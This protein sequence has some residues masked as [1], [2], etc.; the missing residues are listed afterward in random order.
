M[1]VI[2]SICKKFGADKKTANMLGDMFQGFLLTFLIGTWTWMLINDSCE[3][4]Q[5]AAPC[6]CKEVYYPPVNTQQYHSNGTMYWED[7]RN[8]NLTQTGT[9]YGGFGNDI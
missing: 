1:R 3:I 2:E 8:N 5:T 6:F 4:C 7:I 9:E